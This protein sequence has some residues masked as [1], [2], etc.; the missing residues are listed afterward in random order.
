MWTYNYTDELYHHGIKGQRWGVRRPQTTLD[1]LAGRVNKAKDKET[2][3]RKKLTA[4]TSR[5]NINDSD[6][7]RFEYR[8]QNLATRVG[9]TAAGVVAGRLVADVIS[10][11]V[12]RYASMSKSDIAKELRSIAFSTAKNVVVKD[13]LAKSAAKNYTND[14]KRVKGKKDNRLITKEDAIEAGITAVSIAA[15]G[16]A[17]VAGMKMNQARAKRA[18]NEARFRSWGSNILDDKVSNII[19]ISDNDWKVVN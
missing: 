15:P 9:K 13:A 1:R 6:R 10:G 8:N 11:N 3:Y 16:L 7:K 17:T 18:E 12:T 14:G 19:T 2:A 4:I 5:E